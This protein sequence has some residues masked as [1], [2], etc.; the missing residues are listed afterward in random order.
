MWTDFVEKVD[1]VEVKKV[2]KNPFELIEN[3]YHP[4]LITEYKVNDFLCK[5]FFDIPLDDK[6]DISFYT[7]Y[8]L[9][10]EDYIGYALL[11]SSD[12]GKPIRFDFEINDE[13]GFRLMGMSKDWIA[14][15]YPSKKDLTLS[16]FGD[17]L[18]KMDTYKNNEEYTSREDEGM[19]ER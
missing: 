10:T 18:Q 14:E 7:E 11:K 15:K 19:D 9:K 1:D 12:G 17:Y 4:V 16:E 8:D 13:D 5:N 3:A 2:L 6:G